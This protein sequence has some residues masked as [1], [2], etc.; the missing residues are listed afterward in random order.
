MNVLLAQGGIGSVANVRTP[1]LARAVADYA[2][3]LDFRCQQMVRGVY[4]RLVHG[5][6][7]VQL[8]ACGARPARWE[9]P[10]AAEA[11]PFE[12]ARLRVELRGLHALHASLLRAAAAPAQRLGA[13]PIWQPWGAW[14]TTLTDIDGNVLHLID[15][16][17]GSPARAATPHAPRAEVGR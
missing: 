9:K 12:P 8:W 11:A 10:T 2:R 15:R 1:D 17:P 16:A 5:P 3:G 6:L 7:C 13:A 14:E 4:A